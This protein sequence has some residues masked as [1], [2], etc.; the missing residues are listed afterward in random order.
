MSFSIRLLTLSD[1]RAYKALRDASLRDFPEAF[2]SDFETAQ[3]L[4]AESYATRICAPGEHGNQ[5]WG[6]F[7]ADGQLL[8][9][10]ALERAAR[11][12]QR[13]VGSVQGLF[14]SRHA[15]G[16]GIATHLIAACADYSRASG[17]Y[18][19]LILTVTAS[20]THVVNMY[21]KAGFERYGLHPRAV[22]Q[23]GQFH[24]KLLMRLDVRQSS[25]AP[26]KLSS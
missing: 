13:H 26:D 1:L 22:L 2:T 21:E 11:L 15:Q 9:S 10:I 6:A 14:V 20:S 12:Q 3:R 24:D 16:L 25:A 7:D 8:G 23:A 5:L 4:S 18:D 19:H 17:Q